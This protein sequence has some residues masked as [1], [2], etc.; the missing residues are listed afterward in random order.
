MR[1][2]AS[3]EEALVEIERLR[4]TAED[5][6]DFVENGAVG[7]HWEDA[8]GVLI[9]VNQAELDLLGYSRAEYIGRNITEFHT[10]PVAIQDILERLSRNETLHNYPSTMRAKDGS[11]RHVLMTSNVRWDGDRFL[12]TRCFTRD[13]TALRQAE[14]SLRESERRRQLAM[15]AARIGTWEY[16][17]HTGKVVWTGIA[18]IHGVS[19]DSF[20]GSFESYLADVHPE[21]REYVLR[22]SRRRSKRDGRSRWNTGSYG[23]AEKYAGS[24]ARGR[25]YGMQPVRARA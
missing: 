23:L 17:V 25:L 21:D 22:P 3:L 15:E 6:E 14:T 16:D 8:R 10:D 19:E 5:L 12:H 9:W 24:E 2:P 1:Q 18:P 4:A 7:L 11:I 20:G 13:I